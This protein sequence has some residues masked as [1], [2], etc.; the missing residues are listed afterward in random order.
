VGIGISNPAYK[1]VVSNGGNGGLEFGPDGIAAGTSFIQAYDRAASQYDALRLYSSHYQF[2]IGAGTRA[3]DIDTA[4]SLLVGKTASSVS[5]DGV[6]LTSTGFTRATVNGDTVLQLNRRTS[7]GTII[8]FRKD[9]TTVGSIGVN[10]SDNMYFESSASSHTGLTFPDNAI[11]PRK[12]GSNND[13]GVDLGASSVRFKDFYLSGDI[14]HKD[15]ADNAR[16]LYDKSSNLLGNAGT[17]LYGA[18]IYLGGTGAANKLDDY[19]EGTW[20]PVIKAIGTGGNNA[21]YNVGSSGYTKVGRSVTVH[22]YISSININAITG[23]TY[24]TLQGLPFSSTNYGDFT[25]AYKGGSWATAGNIIGGYVQDGTSY[26][27]FM[28]ADGV[29]ANQTSTDVTMTK[30]MISITYQAA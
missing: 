10:S 7:D 29:E 16:L 12:N 6:E 22:T 4:G 5:T 24:I 28:R 11:V 27:Y 19:E 2:F 25:I 23:G 18:G 13:A 3:L 14:A 9:S 21:T 17:N 15:A 1:L 8:N 30:A 20:T 26:A